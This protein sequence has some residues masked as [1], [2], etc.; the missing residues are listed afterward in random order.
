[1]RSWYARC[2]RV[3]LLQALALMSGAA[4]AADAP[5]DTASIDRAT[6]LKGT[7]VE[8]E[9]V[10]KIALPR[11]DVK[12]TVD[13]MPL[14]PFMGLTSTALFTRGNDGKVMMMG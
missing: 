4:A 11:G 7:Y 2:A 13:G 6:G 8:K 10:Y 5:F 12:V 3:T 14:A 1:M 9:G